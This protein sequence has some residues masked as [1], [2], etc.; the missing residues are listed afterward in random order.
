[1]K[2]QKT[3]VVII[4]VILIVVGAFLYL[5]FKD[6][7]SEK[8]SLDNLDYV[9]T[10]LG[11]GI[12]PPDGFSENESSDKNQATFFVKDSAGYQV[13]LFEI[14]PPLEEIEDTNT[15]QYNLSQRNLSYEVTRLLNWF[16]NNGSE[17]NSVLVSHSEKTINGLDAHAFITIWNNSEAISEIKYYYVYVEKDDKLFLLKYLTYV[18]LFD[19]YISVVNDSINSFMTI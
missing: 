11:F 12:N 6:E 7:S 16:E 2:S 1:M 14:I 8:N 3:I 17:N 13:A 5:N 18:E 19:I 4:V 9:N 10:Y 15:M